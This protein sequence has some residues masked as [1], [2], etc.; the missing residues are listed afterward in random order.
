MSG[1]G[2]LPLP[3]GTAAFDDDVELYLSGAADDAVAARLNAR[4]RDDAQA[5][6]RFIALARLHGH[7]GEIGRRSASGEVGT[8]RLLAIG[9]APELAPSTR[10]VRRPRRWLALTAA[11][12]ALLA[13]GLAVLSLAVVGLRTRTLVPTIVASDGPG[14]VLR[15][16]RPLALAGGLRLRVG[17][18]IVTPAGS[19]VSI[20]LAGGRCTIGGGSEAVVEAADRVHRRVVLSRGQMSADLAG[21]DLFAVRTP[22]ATIRLAD[23]AAAIDVSSGLTA[24]SVRRGAVVI[25]TPDGLLRTVGSGGRWS[26]ATLPEVATR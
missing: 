23:A 16:G 10:T 2:P 19:G 14:E 21:S 24:V 4:L 1:P 9:P 13:L 22:D 6:G 12:A 20:T 15:G 7:L 26:S 18:R 17:D 8:A 11:T 25:A 5:R 3:E